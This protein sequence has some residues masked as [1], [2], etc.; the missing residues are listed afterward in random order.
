MTIGRAILS[1]RNTS[2]Y[3]PKAKSEEEEGE[4]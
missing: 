3:Y 1:G 4:E 2:F